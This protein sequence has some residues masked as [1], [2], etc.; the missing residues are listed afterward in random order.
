MSALLAHEANAIR[1]TTGIPVVDGLVGLRTARYAVGVMN[2]VKRFL[3]GV[4]STLFV[5]VGLARAA[6]SFEPVTV[7]VRSQ[8]SV[9]T[10]SLDCAGGDCLVNCNIA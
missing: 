8:A 3:C 10:A 1:Q 7:S 5:A 9:A 4:L 2:T 6:E